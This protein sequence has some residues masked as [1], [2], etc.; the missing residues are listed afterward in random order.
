MKLAGMRVHRSERPER[1]ERRRA[2]GVA[3]SLL[4]DITTLVIA[5]VGRDETDIPSIRKRCRRGYR[6]AADVGREVLAGES[7]AVG[8]K[9]CRCSLEDD[10]AAVVPC[11]RT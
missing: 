10:P 7:G 8:D 2:P 6:L 1:P 11:A 9:V 4:V 3:S 5:N